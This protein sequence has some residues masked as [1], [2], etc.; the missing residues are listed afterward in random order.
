MTFFLN[1]LGKRYDF[2]FYLMY[3]IS[4]HMNLPL[5][6][7]LSLLEKTCF[8]LY[9]LSYDLGKSIY[10]LFSLIY[11]LG[12]ESL[13]LS[14]ALKET[15]EADSSPSVMPLDKV[16]NPITSSRAMPLGKVMNHFFSHS[17]AI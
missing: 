6:S 16:L 1:A 3:I 4:K 17:Y 9:S 13:T 7:Q 12:K 2:L 15:H 8:Y 5:L 14:Y 11:A 10:C